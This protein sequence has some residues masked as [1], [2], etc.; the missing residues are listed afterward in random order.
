MGFFNPGDLV[1]VAEDDGYS[2]EIFVVLRSYYD[3]KLMA[4]RVEVLDG[5]GKAKSYPP[6][7]FT[8]LETQT[9]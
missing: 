9:C 5:R 3:E 8:S 7:W 1:Y 6:L 2:K 4:L